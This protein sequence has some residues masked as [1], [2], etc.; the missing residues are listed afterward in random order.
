MKK[1]LL[2]AVSLIV[3]AFYL[4]S[5][6]KA[7]H[8]IMRLYKEAIV[9]INQA[10]LVNFKSLIVV[11]ELDGAGSQELTDSDQIWRLKRQ[12][13]YNVKSGDFHY[14]NVATYE[15]PA[16]DPRSKQQDTSLSFEETGTLLTPAIVEAYYYDQLLRYYDRDQES[17]LGS[18]FQDLY[19][20][21]FLPFHADLINRQVEHIDSEN[22]G[23]FVVYTFHVDPEFLTR[24]FPQLLVADDL[25]FEPNFLEGQI[26]ILI[27]PDTS[28]TRRIYSD[29]VLA[30]PETGK[31]YAYQ[32]DSY[33]SANEDS[34]YFSLLPEFQWPETAPPE[35]Q[36]PEIEPAEIDADYGKES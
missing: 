9:S 3:L 23:K 19:L 16:D 15:Y 21:E 13:V 18:D 11:R 36:D 20:F 32:V 29:F 6:L 17:W 25:D 10:E 12:G 4:G 27:Y 7:D 22:R 24:T 35:D 8:P 14:K 5:V 31:R 34:N 28:L 26:K 2:I 30:N 1:N 33:Y